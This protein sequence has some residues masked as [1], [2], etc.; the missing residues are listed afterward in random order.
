MSFPFPGGDHR[1]RHKQSSGSHPSNRIKP[2][3]IVHASLIV[4]APIRSCIP[5]F[6]Q[7]L[8]KSFHRLEQVALFFHTRDSLV[9]TKR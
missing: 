6:R 5:F 9:G 2:E 4:L 3:M 8:F 7:L 1:V